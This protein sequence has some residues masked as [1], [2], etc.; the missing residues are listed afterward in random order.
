[1]SGISA[2]LTKE[3]ILRKTG[4][5]SQLAGI[6]P[7]VLREGRK[8][9]L[10]AF[11]V[12][13][14]GGL[15]FTVLEGRC[16]DILSAKYKGIN[17]SFISKPG[18]VSPQYFNPYG[19]EQVRTTQAGMMFTCGLSNVGSACSENDLE[20]CAHGRI[21]HTPAEKVCTSEEWKNGEYHMEISGMM[22]ESAI[23]CENLVLK[24]KIHTV[25]GAKSLK[26]SDE[27][28]NQ[29]FQDQPI[30]ILYHFNFGYPLL[31]KDAEVFVPS[32][33]ITPRDSAAKKGVA[34]WQQISPPID[35]YSEQV[36][37]HK[38]ACDDNGFTYAGVMNKK[39]MLGA[40]I[41]YRKAELSQL[42]QW[43][44]M[45]PGDYAL[46]LEP[47]NCLVEGR[48]KERERGTLF[49]LPPLQ[50]VSFSV[51]LIVLDGDEEMGEFERFLKTLG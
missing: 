6:R 49:S 40:Y 19:G 15:E 3:T 14:G 10:G 42:I 5:I 47:S 1:M 46:G 37:Y 25:L 28:E 18:L 11:E 44:S 22:R 31:D 24:R 39:R 36:F 27:V 4:N 51:E 38:S 26:I 23:M 35:G 20:F 34:F 13:T 41:K 8:E 32:L 43:K 12:V 45:A 2:N 30:M 29:G 21:G 17:L 33:E 48:V 50:S 7:C 16:L 9:G